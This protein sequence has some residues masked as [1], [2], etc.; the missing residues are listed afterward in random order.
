MLL[1][2][3]VGSKKTVYKENAAMKKKIVVMTV[4]PKGCF[5]IE[6]DLSAII[7]DRIIHSNVLY[8]STYNNSLEQPSSILEVL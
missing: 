4:R 5:D 8:R 1:L 6:S 7:T 2:I 3:F